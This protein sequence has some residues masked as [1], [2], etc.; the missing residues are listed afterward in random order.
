MDRRAFLRRGLATGALW[1][2]GPMQ[3][4]AALAARAGRRRLGA[5]VNGSYGELLPALDE[6]TG[7]P[8]LLLP[9]GFRYLSFGYRGDPLEDETPT[10]ASHDGM[11][12]FPSPDGRVLIVRNHEVRSASSSFGPERLTYDP[13]AGGGT[14]TLLFDP[15]PGRYVRSWSSLAGT[16]VNCAGGPTPWGTWLSCEETLEGPESGGGLTQPHGYV[17]EVPSLRE[18]R[19]IPLTAM[20]RFAHEAVAVDPATGIVYETEDQFLSGF[21][22]FLPNR[23]QRLAAGGTL[24]MLAVQGLP[25]FQTHIGQQVGLPLPV[26]WIT[27][28]DPECCAGTAL[29]VFTQG[30]SLG[31]AVFRRGE[32]AWYDGGKIYFTATW[33]G[34]AGIGQ[35]WVYDPTAETLALLFESA[36]I[37]ELDQPD[38]LTVSPRGGIVVCE[39]TDLPVR[40]RGL[41]LEGEIF[42]FAQN[43]VVLD[44]EPH[45]ILGDFRNSEFAGA[46]FS[47]DGRWLFVNV[48]SPGVTFAI[49]GP[50]ERGAL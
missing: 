17:F 6:T 13:A 39:D 10:P 20:G 29:G 49:T 26:L 22:R 36:G 18:A 35:I 11:A 50:W 12:A 48:Q 3:G 28:P 23:S 30:F 27:I 46:C 19:P 14:T 45:G 16:M 21:Y 8:L 24:Q 34:D 41:T 25:Q 9:E 33:G 38:N 40:L 4:F 1:A 5:A 15:D 32:G 42:P 31:G 44:G 47:P 7:L 37:E 43:N 2:A